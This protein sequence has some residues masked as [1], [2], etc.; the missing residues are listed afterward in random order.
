MVHLG[1]FFVQATL[2]YWE[3][4]MK[5]NRTA[6]KWIIILKV[7]PTTAVF[8]VMTELAQM[9]LTNTRSADPWD[10]FADIVGVGMATFS[11]ILIYK[12]VKK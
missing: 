5:S 8:A 3:A 7:I 4:S 1:I 10:V 12:R 6:N 11:F 2:L 9:Y